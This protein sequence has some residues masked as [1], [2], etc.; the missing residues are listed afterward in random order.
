VHRWGPMGSDGIIS[1]THI[2]Q[3]SI[4]SMQSDRV[5]YETSL[6]NQKNSTAF[7]KYI[8]RQTKSVARSYSIVDSKN[9]MTSS[10]S[11]VAE[12]FSEFFATVCYNNIDTDDGKAPTN[13]IVAIL[14]NRLSLVYFDKFDVLY[15]L[16]SL[17]VSAAG[18]DGISAIIFKKLAN[19]LAYP[20]ST[21]YNLLMQKGT[22]PQ[23][24]KKTIVVPIFKQGNSSIAS[25]YRPISI[26]C[27]TC[28]IFERCVKDSMLK[29][30]NEHCFISSKQHGFLKKKSTCLNLLE[31]MD[32]WT[33]C[34]DE[35]Q[36]CYVAYIDFVK[37]FDM[38]QTNMLLIKL[39]LLGICGMLL[40][41]IASLLP[42]RTQRVKV[43]N[44][45]SKPKPV[46][47]GVVQGSVLGP[48]L[49]IVFIN[50]VFNYLP[51]IAKAKLFADDLKSYIIAKKDDS[52]RNFPLI[53]NGICE[54]AKQWKLNISIEKSGWM[55]ISN[56]HLATKPTFCLGGN[57]LNEFLS[58]K[59]LGLQYNGHLSFS[60]HIN[61]IVGKA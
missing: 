28:K 27:I 58:V 21:I 4:I 7:H 13:S 22:V 19:A 1:Y 35:H 51:N 41:C 44:C 42:N 30:F 5:N 11:G 52:A 17:R 54:W 9:V 55:R 57:V 25:N 40:E 12:I 45:L 18:P 60:Q 10:D 49:F 56:N 15:H 43:R 8:R 38:V 59:D 20:L 23:I 29:Y 3:L 47:M 50:D 24:W 16:S 34:I 2:R 48:T 26:T 31:C 61:S 33:K 46:N 32:D 36:E 14:P 53:L 6:M 39:R 37:A